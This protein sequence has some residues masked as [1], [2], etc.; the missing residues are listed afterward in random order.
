MVHVLK[1]CLVYRKRAT[2]VKDLF[3]MVVGEVQI[4]LVAMADLGVGEEVRPPRWE[5]VYTHGEV[6]SFRL[7]R[8]SRRGRRV[9]CI[10]YQL[11]CID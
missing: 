9:V 8:G 10:I 5:G 6:Y 4:R 2:Q 7:V 1:W 3:K 11:D